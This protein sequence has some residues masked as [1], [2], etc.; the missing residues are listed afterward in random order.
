MSTPFKEK[1]SDHFEDLPELKLLTNFDVNLTS[2]PIGA[3]NETFNPIS[4]GG[5]PPLEVFPSPSP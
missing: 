2:S 3:M 5:H 4:A 1:S